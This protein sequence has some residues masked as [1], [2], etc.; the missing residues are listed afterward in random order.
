MK[1]GRKSAMGWPLRELQSQATKTFL[2]EA[3]AGAKAPG[4][5]RV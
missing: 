3:A 4:Q 1:R 2:A 5:G